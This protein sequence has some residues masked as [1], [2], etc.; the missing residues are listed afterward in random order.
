MNNIKSVF[1]FFVFVLILS[2]AGCIQKGYCPDGRES[3]QLFNP[4]TGRYEASCT[5]YSVWCDDRTGLCWQAPQR[6]AYYFFDGGL[7]QPDAIL[8]CDELVFAGYDDWR[9][10]NIDE[11]RTLIRGN[12]G[13]ETGGDCPITEGSPMSD[14]EHEACYS[15]NRLWG[16]PGPGGCY[17]MSELEGTCNKPDPASIGHPMEYVSSTVAS[18]SGD[19]VACVMFENGIVMFNHLL[20]YSDVRCVRD[21]PTIPVEEM[22]EP[23]E[24][25]PG[26]TRKCTDGPEGKIG[27]QV[28]A[29][30][31]NCWLPCEYTGFTPTPP[32]DLSQFCDRVELTIKVPER[33]ARP[34]GSLM[35]FF[36]QAEGWSW[37]PNRPPDGGTDYNQ[38]FL[39]DIDVE[40]PFKMTVPACTYYRERC[41]TGEYYLYV[42]L[43]QGFGIPPIMMRGDY[44]WGMEQEPL[45]F[46]FGRDHEQQII[47]MEITL[48]P[49]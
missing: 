3:I 5:Y 18:D 16:G 8:Y 1:S 25:V 22:C 13:T 36:Y 26:E 20:G 37:P 38:V 17:W 11:L 40:R 14:M 42:A 44:W 35:A 27:A 32:Q 31:G 46:D 41:L 21:G 28:C 2:L 24:C 33:L 15:P 12:P 47:D 48:V 7:T 9:L 39:P 45:T 30:K 23:G 34:Y 29:D 6:N 49:Y 43:M 10:P 4:V 19:W